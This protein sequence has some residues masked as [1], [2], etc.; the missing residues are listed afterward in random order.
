MLSKVKGRFRQLRRRARHRRRPAR[1]PASRRPSTSRPS[2]RTTRAATPTLRSSDFFDC[3]ATPDD[4]FHHWH[5]RS[6][7]RVRRR[8]R[9]CRCTASPARQP[10]AGAPRV[11]RG[12]TVRRHPVGFLGDRR[13]SA[14]AIRHH[15]RIAEAAASGS[16]T[17]CRSPSKVEAVLQADLTDSTASV[18]PRRPRPPRRGAGH[19]SRERSE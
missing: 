4:D 2:I 5:P 11:P 14:A 7:Q 1:F 15:L 18:D 12:V 8:R 6:R 13:E 9:A 17:R 19:A 10:R 16:A 3:R